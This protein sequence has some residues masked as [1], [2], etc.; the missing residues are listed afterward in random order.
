MKTFF[1]KRTFTAAAIAGILYGTMP[2]RA[3]DLVPVSDITGGSSVFV[4]RSAAKTKPRA[5][6][7][8]SRPTVS[9][10]QRI[11]TVK[12]VSK[13]YVALAKTAPRRT[14]TDSVAPETVTPSKIKT[15]PPD[16]ASRLFAGV[17]EYYIDRDDLDNAID[18]FRESVSLDKKNVRASAGLSEALAL[19]GN[20][21]LVKDAPQ[22][23]RKFF[24]EALTYNPKNSPAYFGLAEVLSEDNKD[25]D[26]IKNYESALT[27]DKDLTEI[28]VPLGILYYQQGQIAK[29]EAMLTKALASAGSDSDASLQ[30]FVGL[31]RYSQSRDQEALT[32]F[33]KAKKLDPTYYE[34]FYQSGMTLARLDRN[35]EAV[36]DFKQAIVIKP[37]Y[38]EAQFAL[39]SAYYEMGN[40][41]EAIKAY[42]QAVR[43]RNDSIEAYE[44]LGDAY[45][46]A[47][48]Y[49]KAESNY[50][51]ATTFI[52]RKP[53]YSRNEAA[54]VYSKTA[55]VLAKQCEI[56]TRKAVPCKWDAAIRVLEKSVE[57][58]ATNVDY[59]NLGWAYYNASMVDKIDKRE[60][61]SK[62][63]LEKAKVNL[64]RA[65]A[66]NPKFITGP[67]LNLGMVLTDLG[68]YPAAVEALTNVVKK[69]PKWVFALNELGI[70]YRLQN[71][72]KDAAD[73]FRKAIAKDDK[74]AIGYYNLGEAEFRAGNLGEAKKAYDKLKKLGAVN[75]ANQ[76]ELISGGQIRG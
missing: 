57:L 25:D 45:R 64:Q 23:A 9:K 16:Q 33:Q 27:N 58:G 76:L 34:A 14:R 66:S 74:Y 1:S 71:K 17:G 29:S 11:E 4:S 50:N 54:D 20:D 49:N 26:A 47:G 22:I 15:M 35:N 70:A 36:A 7:T 18:S 48:D 67:Q 37:N 75:L 44:N 40:Y 12:R 21:L 68:E 59:A 72:Y 6:V 8:R 39:G 38:F 73:Q 2:V 3:Q 53:D 60:A 65:V 61:E 10:A 43:L 42:G 30:Y 52:A 63:K 28:Y 41:P 19:K 69:E 31:I 56:N 46:E 5:T 51:L 62:V 13:Q 32:A 55:F 24:E